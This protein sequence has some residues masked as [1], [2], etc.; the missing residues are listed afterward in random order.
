MYIDSLTLSFMDRALLIGSLLV[1]LAIFGCLFHF[2][3]LG[4]FSLGIERTP[5][6]I[7]SVLLIMVGVFFI[8]KNL[9]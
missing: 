6:G 8:Y 7:I 5:A 4:L 9:F 3:R 1:G 2:L